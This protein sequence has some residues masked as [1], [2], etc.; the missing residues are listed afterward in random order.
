MSTLK[1][2][3]SLIELL[4][5]VA[6]IGILAAVGTVGY[7]N[8]IDGTKERVAISNAETLAKALQSADLAASAGVGTT[9][10]CGSGDTATACLTQIIADSD[11]A[12]PYNTAS[13]MSITG[14]CAAVA[15]RG[16]LTVT[17]GATA[18]ITVCVGG[19]DV[20]DIGAS[21]VL[22]VTLDNVSGT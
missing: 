11:F 9:D 13:Q 17:N 5:V 12:N 20:S 10:N 21:D 1:Q 18:T 4:V 14:A 7:Q 3:F 8:Y 19:A 15:D 22:S 6:I 16:N 2:G